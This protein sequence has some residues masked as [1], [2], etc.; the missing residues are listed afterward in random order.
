M[1]EKSVIVIGAGP[2]GYVSA[3]KAAQVGARVTLIE[4]DT[5][6]GTC[7]NRG[8]IPTKVFLQSAELV[9]GIK[10]AKT[11]G[12][13]TNGVSFDFSE[14]IQRKNKVVKQL[15]SGLQFLM[16]K[17]KI[18]VVKGTGTLIDK[19]SVGIIGSDEK[20]EGDNIIIATGSKPMT[21]TI[22]GIN[23]ENIL[24]SDGLINMSSL[25][26]S[27]IIIGGGFIG[28]EFAQFLTNLGCKVTIVEKL[29]QIL[30]LGDPEIAGIF[31]IILRDKGVEVFTS[32]VVNSIRDDKNGKKVLFETED[33][34]QEKIAERVL[35]TVG[36]EPETKNLGLEKVGIS[37]NRGRIVTN[38]RM[39]TSVSGIYAI[40]DVLGRIMLAHVAMS[41]AECAV[42]NIFNTKTEIDYRVVPSCTYTSPEIASVGLTEPEAKDRYE[43]VKVGR[44]PYTA[45]ARAAIFNRTSG[46]VKI[47]ADGQSGEILGVQIL[48]PQATELIAEATMA[49]RMEATVEDIVQ[50]IHAH[51]TLSEALM[52]AALVTK[53]FPIHL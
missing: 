16:R 48:G 5:L 51:P 39:E 2:G 22:D 52:E 4:K 41:E 9:V 33:G 37:V 38:N 23:G 24:N 35:I 50:T 11:F 20:L 7:T 18:R 3:I 30:P 12:V 31:E 25:P 19:R 47:I 26:K 6:G 46:L 40:G 1:S 8:C 17:N 29:S 49:M 32:A 28:L 53:G 43:K 44:F 36:R 45:N 42:K 15:V 27:V 21:M 14:I 13:S 34:R 10:E